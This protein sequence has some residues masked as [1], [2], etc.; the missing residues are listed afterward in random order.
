MATA[1][2]PLSPHLQIY[3]PQLTSVLSITHRGTGLFLSL[4]SLVLAWWL[5]SIASGPQSFSG[6]QSHITAWYGQLAL[7]AW[8]FAFY[9]HLANGI[10]HLFWDMG[11]GL[12]IDTAYRSGFIVIGVSLLL[13]V[14]TVIYGYASLGGAA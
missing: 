11:K 9:Y 7:L 2:R 8:I 10:R 12:E 5:F 13:A 6:A 1:N 4:G 14:A 3:K